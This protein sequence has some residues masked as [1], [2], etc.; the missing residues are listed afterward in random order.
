MARQADSGDS[1]V[2]QLRSIVRA[3][4]VIAY[5]D[6][7]LNTTLAS[8]LAGNGRV[9]R[10]VIV[11]SIGLANET[12][13]NVLA[14]ASSAEMMHRASVIIDDIEDDD[15][16]RRGRPCLHAVVGLSRALA[17]ADLILSEAMQRFLTVGSPYLREALSTY[18]EMAKGQ[19][20]DVGAIVQE[21]TD[22]DEPATLKTGL[23]VRMCFRFGSR[24]AGHPEDLINA[25]G[26]IGMHL[27]SAFQLQNDINNYVGHDPRRSQGSSDMTRGNNSSIA[28]AALGR[29]KAHDRDEG[30]IAAVRA[31]RD[32]HLTAFRKIILSGKIDIPTSLQLVIHDFAT[33]T[34]FVGD[35]AAVV[36][37][38]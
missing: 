7:G 25:Y 38:N 5:S 15:T 1:V 23:L 31:R 6:A 16:T 18:A 32:G 37:E 28:L 17:I 12:E 30:A 35:Q 26:E 27:G 34:E 19:A 8:A 2:E 20:L 22:I 24:A 3:A 9:N 33:A 13:T 29:S 10:G 4:L 36:D 21:N 14:L 11:Y